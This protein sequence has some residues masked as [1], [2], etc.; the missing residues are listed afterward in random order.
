MASEWRTYPGETSTASTAFKLYYEMGPGRS[1]RRLAKAQ[2]RPEERTLAGW[3]SKD[4]WQRRATEGDSEELK[5]GT[6][7][8]RATREAV[9][10]QLFDS[11]IDAARIIIAIKRGRMPDGDVDPL[12]DRHGNPILDAEGNQICRPRIKASTRLQAAIR[13]LE[14]I[15]ITPPKRVEMSG[16]DGMEVGVVTEMFDSLSDEALDKVMEILDADR[17]EQDKDSNSR[18]AVPTAATNG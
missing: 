1:L 15:G 11:A 14:S 3:S 18:S 16:P 2:G 12:L 13:I 7:T 9:M 17:E 4:E 8:R 10:Q 5:R 6:E